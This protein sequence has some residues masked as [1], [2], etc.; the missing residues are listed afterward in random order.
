MRTCCAALLLVCGCD[1]IY[2]GFLNSVPVSDDESIGTTHVILAIDGLSKAAFDAA[3]TQ[4]AFSEWYAADLVTPFPSTSD[5]SWTRTLRTDPIPGYELEYYD[6]AT[7]SIVNDGLTGIVEHPFETGILD[8]RPCYAR[9]DYLGNGDLW[10]FRNYDDPEEALPAILDEMFD[11]INVRARRQALLLAYLPNVDVIAHLRPFERVV[12]A[13]MEIDR[14][15]RVFQERHPD[16]F[17]FSIIADHGNTHREAQLVDLEEA[18]DEV[19]VDSV[20]SLRPEGSNVLEAVPIIHTRVSYV[21]LHAR[22]EQTPEI[23]RRISTHR[24][25]DNAVAP[26]G[27]EVFDDEPARRY[28]FWRTGTRREFVVLESG[29]VV[30]ENAAEWLAIGVDLGSSTGMVRIADRDAFDRTFDAPWPDLFHQVDQA[31]TNPAVDTPADILVSFPDD[32]ASFGFHLPGGG[33]RSAT[34]G[35]HGSLR[36]APTMAAV[37]TQVGP[38]PP[39]LRSNDLADLLPL[40]PE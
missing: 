26:L 6:A 25:V 29:D 3:R 40:A 11:V 36:R 20:T 1:G 13:L 5:Y 7:N 17:V 32:L 14:R 31:F 23:A 28:G 35:F 21:A 33:D 39:R 8:A 34:Q 15:I 12:A 38:L 37:A 27:D 10:M 24:W 19:G 9:F 4:G 2:A 22:R 30:V 18:L 16:R